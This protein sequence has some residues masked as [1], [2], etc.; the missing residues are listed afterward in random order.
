MLKQCA[1]PGCTELIE[2]HQLDAV[3]PDAISGARLMRVL[4]LCDSPRQERFYKDGA[5]RR[6]RTELI[7]EGHGECVLCRARGRYSRAVMVHHVWFLS[8]HPELAYARH[9]YSGGRAYPQLLPLCHDCHEAVHE[10]RH[11]EKRDPITLERW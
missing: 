8:A 5:W 3:Q 2:L 7:G 4:R 1:R 9:Y 6:L 11:A 10:H